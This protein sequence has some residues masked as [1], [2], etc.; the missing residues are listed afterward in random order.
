MYV[1]RSQQKKVKF[2]EEIAEDDLAAPGL[3]AWMNKNTLPAYLNSITATHFV[4]ALKESKKAVK[5]KL[6][7][8]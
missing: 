1:P 7:G 6:N 2:I 3:H 5:G 8:C 4:W